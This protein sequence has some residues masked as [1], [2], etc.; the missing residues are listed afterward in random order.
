MAQDSIC[1]LNSTYIYKWIL[2][3]ESRLFFVIQKTQTEA[4]MNFK[5]SHDFRKC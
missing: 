3:R 2:S 1:H 4:V 5:E